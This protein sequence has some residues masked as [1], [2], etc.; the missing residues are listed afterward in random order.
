[1]LNLNQESAVLIIIDVQEN[2]FKVIEK[3]D[4]NILSDNILK[5]I[6][7]INIFNI[8]IIISEQF[9]R[10]FGHTINPI[11][12]LLPSNQPVHK[13]TFNCYLEHSF[14]EALEKIDKKQLIIAG[15][16]THI[17]VLQ[18]ALTL[19]NNGYEVYIV[20]DACGA[21]KK[22]DHKTALKL[23]Q[24]SDIKIVTY[25]MIIFQLMQSA[26]DKNYKKILKIINN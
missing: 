18:T 3:N 16:E 4:N 21:R 20:S 12:E 11:L 8:P 13:M 25:E 7:S 17:C 2:L 6:K 24:K 22:I 23:M 14:R 26:T 15:I 5:L 19:K 9:P 1:M 10:F